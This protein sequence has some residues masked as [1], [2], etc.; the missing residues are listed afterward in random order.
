MLYLTVILLLLLLIYYY[1]YKQYINNRKQW[2]ISVG[3]IFMLMAGLRYRLGIDTLEYEYQFTYFPDLLEF[4]SFNFDE[5]E[6]G[7]GFMLFAALAKSIYD[8]FIVLQIL[9]AIFVTF[10]VFKFFYNNSKHPFFAILLYLII[11]YFPLTFEVMRESCAVCMLLIGWKY[12]K[13]NKW[14]QYYICAVIGIMFHSSAII[15]LILPFFYLPVFRFLFTMGKAFWITVAIVFLL[16]YIISE[17]FFSLIKLIQISDIEGYANKYEKSKYAQS[18]LLN[19]F[20]II[21]FAI[22]NLLYPVIAVAILKSKNI[23]KSKNKLGDQDINKL[24]YMFCWFVYIAIVA[25]F[26]KIF[27]RFNNY[28]YPFAIL[29]ISDAIFTKFKRG[30]KINSWTFGIWLLLITPYLSIH[31]YGLFEEDGESGIPII[32]KYYP[33]ESVIDP[34]LDPEREKLYHFYG[35]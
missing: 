11:F 5:T 1:D 17:Q 26:I 28:F 19:I 35:K 34:D 3:I 15:M 25:L 18:T 10:V 22:R 12:F 24:E 32:R 21:T 16:S 30:K 29:A 27:Y 20:G 31:I 9:H 6:Y 4:G 2:Y 14:I 23:V 33:Y 8:D 7:R 13:E